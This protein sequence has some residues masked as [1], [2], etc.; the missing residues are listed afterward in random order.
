MKVFKLTEAQ[1]EQLKTVEF[2]SDNF[3]NP[4]QDANN[5]WIITQQEID[6]TTDE[7]FTWVKDLPQIDFIKPKE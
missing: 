4:I 2:V 3:Y 5:V 1:K 6:Q 7:N